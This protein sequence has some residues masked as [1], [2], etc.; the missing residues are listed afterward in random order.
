MNVDFGSH[1]SQDALELYALGMLSAQCCAT[2]EE[3]LLICPRC[4]THLEAA[5]R[6]ISLVRSAYVLISSRSQSFPR[7]RA[8][9]VAES[10]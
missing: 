10:L 8:M 1:F 3:H 9:H 4:Q 5:D 7:P 2:L 6:Y